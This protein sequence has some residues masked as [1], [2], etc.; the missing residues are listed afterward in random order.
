[1][2]AK[3]LKGFQFLLVYEHHTT[4][5][6]LE[7]RHFTYVLNIGRETLIL[8]KAEFEGKREKRE[9]GEKH[10]PRRV[11]FRHFQNG[12]KPM[13]P[14]SRLFIHKDDFYI[15][16]GCFSA[17]TSPLYQGVEAAKND[18]NVQDQMVQKTGIEERKL[19]GSET[20]RQGGSGCVPPFQPRFL[21]TERRPR[22]VE[23]TKM[24]QKYIDASAVKA[25]I[26]TFASGGSTV[27]HIKMSEEILNKAGLNIDDL[28]SVQIVK[29]VGPKN[30]TR[31]GVE[32]A[33]DPTGVKLARRGN[34]LLIQKFNLF[35][36]PHESTVARIA[37]V[38]NGK[39]VVVPLLPDNDRGVKAIKSQEHPVRVKDDLIA[40]PSLLESLT[41]DPGHDKR[42]QHLAGRHAVRTTSAGDQCYTPK[43]L[44]DLVLS[45][46]GRASF[47][48]DIC[49]MQENGQYHFDLPDVCSPKWGYTPMRFRNKE[50]V[51]GHVP[52]HRYFTNDR[53]YGSLGRVWNGEYIWLNPPYTVKSWAT[54]LECAHHQ[55][56]NGHAG[57]VIALVPLSDGRDHDRHMYSQYAYRIDLN[58]SIPFFK[59]EKVDKQGKVVARNIIE[60]IKGNQFVVFGKG[61]K[62]QVFLRRFLKQLRD[63]EYISD[64]HYAR[65]TEMFRLE[66]KRK[67]RQT[68]S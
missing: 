41:L 25:S 9:D 43:F 20:S 28:L 29:L 1:M 50:S 23:M 7:K 60:A 67:K 55:V 26:G 54:F 18:R 21:G 56:K 19:K 34:M 35:A 30:Q 33:I 64:E 65:Y 42:E 49:S 5:E 16:A 59:R 53:P 6:F 32:I 24:N 10:T 58:S 37:E 63:A 51:L 27:T 15:T 47:D 66:A 31:I 4:A 44:I 38:G 12:K 14:S 52:A 40:Y 57:V 68:R 62:V 2:L 39:L 8:S 48:I 22:I 61:Q 11:R 3:K 36:K 46:T 45:A 13:P 17:S